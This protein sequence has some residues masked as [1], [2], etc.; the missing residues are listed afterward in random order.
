MTTKRYPHADVILKYP[1]LRSRELEVRA[2][3][4]LL[5]DLAYKQQAGTAIVSIDPRELSRRLAVTI[6]DA[7]SVLDIL[8]TDKR[9]PWAHHSYSGVERLLELRE[10]FLL[11]A[12]VSPAQADIAAVV[13]DM[14][15]SFTATRNAHEAARLRALKRAQRQS[16]W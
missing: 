16:A 5:T 1:Y 4:L 11:P 8:A 15:R 10:P 12:G 13:A 6:K 9:G 14:E 7:H 2:A 3:S